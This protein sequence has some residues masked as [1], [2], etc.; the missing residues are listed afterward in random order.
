MT[1]KDAPPATEME[2]IQRECASMAKSL[3]MMNEEERQL[4]TANAILARRAVV[5]GCTAG[6]DGGT[7]RGA[8]R[9]AAAKKIASSSSSSLPE[10][11]L[12][13]EGISPAP[14]S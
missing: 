14:S 2:R 5:M 3:V 12:D 11:I 1:T 8:R 10:E 7:R 4:R 6:L 9:K 13:E